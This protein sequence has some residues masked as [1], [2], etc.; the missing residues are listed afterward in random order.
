MKLNGCDWVKP[1]VG[2]YRGV[3]VLEL[4]CCVTHLLVSARFGS[5][6]MFVALC[7]LTPYS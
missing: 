6:D 7:L 1:S 3:Y 4:L 5:G 2:P